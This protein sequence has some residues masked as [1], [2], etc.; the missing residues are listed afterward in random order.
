ML[1]L[2]IPPALG[3]LQSP[4]VLLPD[5]LRLG[6]ETSYVL[7]DGSVKDIGA[8]LLVPAEALPTETIGIRA[9]ATVVRVGDP[10][11]ALGRGSARRLAV[12]AVAAPLADDQALEQISATAGPVAT[13]LPVLLELGLDGQE[14]AFAH[15]P[16]DFDEDLIFRGCINP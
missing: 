3:T 12:A 6:Q 8:D 4:L 14:E 1:H 2:L 9:C 7:P 10:T 15:Q 5:P 13:A 16:G 11:L